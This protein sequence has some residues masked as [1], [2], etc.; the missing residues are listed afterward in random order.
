MIELTARSVAAAAL[1]AFEEGRLAFQNI[2]K[3][4]PRRFLCRYIYEEA[5]G[6]CCAIGAALDPNSDAAAKGTDNSWRVGALID[7]GLIQVPQSDHRT[8]F[9]LQIDHDYLTERAREGL[10]LTDGETRFVTR[11][12]ELAQ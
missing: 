10:S 4:D 11:L 3:L 8:L 6:V 12:R 7:D 1:K 2:D 9:D 5:P